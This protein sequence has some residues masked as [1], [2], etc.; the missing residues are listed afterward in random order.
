[1]EKENKKLR[2]DHRREYIDAVRAL[3][4]FVQHR[5]PRYKA[6]VAEQARAK[7]ARKA[8]G[9]PGAMPASG[10][11]ASTPARKVDAEAARRRAEER[12][13]SAA[14]FEVQEWQKFAKDDTEDEEEEDERAQQA[15]DGTGL[16]MDDGTGGELLECI[17]CNKTF[18]SEASWENHERSKKHKQAVWK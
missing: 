17:A 5:D 4:Q 18:Q 11:G 12:M 10:S 16:R 14:A 13:Q 15:G 2:E 7:K 3:A 6:Y 9:G 1:M 8:A